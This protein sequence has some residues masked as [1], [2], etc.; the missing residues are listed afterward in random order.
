MHRRLRR[1]V[2]E[3]SV[4]GMALHSDQTNVLLFYLF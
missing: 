4:M 1:A 2:G 3:Q